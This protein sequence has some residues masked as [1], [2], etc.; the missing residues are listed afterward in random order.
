MAVAA[1]EVAVEIVV[2]LLKEA[3]KQGLLDRVRNALKKKPR[4]LLL[5][6]SGVGKT[7]MLQSLSNPYPAAI[8]REDRTMYTEAR[9]LVVKGKYYHFIDTPGD[10]YFGR[11]ARKQT[12]REAMAAKGGIAGLLNVVCFGY[13]EYHIRRA[14]VFTGDSTVSPDYLVRHREA[15]INQL[16]E[17]TQVLGD[18]LTSHWLITVVTKADL[19]WNR[20]SE[21]IDYYQKGAYFDAL[22]DAKSLHQRV[23]PY[24]SVFRKFYG[25]GPMC[26]TFDQESRNIARERLLDSLIKALLKNQGA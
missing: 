24:S 9:K 1:G 10:T 4:I 23:L 21:V 20:R 2:T 17:W 19:W 8:R 25:Q 22:G 12:M 14:R 6:C 5:G 7:N 13:H 3:D 16:H 18:V 11:D 26:G 15:E